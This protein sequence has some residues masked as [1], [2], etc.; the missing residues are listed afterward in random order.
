MADSQFREWFK[1]L[2]KPKGRQGD[3]QQPPLELRVLDDT[4]RRFFLVSKSDLNSCPSGE[5]S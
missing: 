4:N 3:W 2:R 5:E 1:N